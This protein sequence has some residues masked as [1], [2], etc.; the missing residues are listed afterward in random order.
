MSL[1]DN[2]NA[3][4]LARKLSNMSSKDIKNI[5]GKEISIND[6]LNMSYHDVLK[7]VDTYEDNLKKEKDT[8][9]VGDKVRVTGSIAKGIII[10]FKQAYMSEELLAEVLVYNTDKEPSKTI[11]H[12]DDLE[13]EGYN[14]KFSYDSD[15]KEVNRANNTEVKKNDN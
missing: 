6:I 15:I 3:W 14:Y 11:Y 10:G 9:R 1:N 12:L 4:R 7:A 8:F 5:F 2:T 13:K